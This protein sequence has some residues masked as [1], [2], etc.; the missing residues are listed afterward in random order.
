MCNSTIG[1]GS[2]KSIKKIGNTQ[3]FSE[4]NRVIVPDEQARYK[5][6]GTI[7]PRRSLSVEACVFSSQIFLEKIAKISFSISNAVS[8]AQYYTKC[9]SGEVL[10]CFPGIK[11]LSHRKEFLAIQLIDCSNK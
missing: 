10:S 5:I 4:V 1:L 7:F 9:V 2:I 3:D 8:H 11:E 6:A